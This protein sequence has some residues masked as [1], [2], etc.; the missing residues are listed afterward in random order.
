MH[1]DKSRTS[2]VFNDHIRR[3]SYSSA[4]RSS[5]SALESDEAA[6]VVPWGI[7]KHTTSLP[8]GG[9]DAA[10]EWLENYLTG[11]TDQYTLG[12]SPSSKVV[13]EFLFLS[14]ALLLRCTC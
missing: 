3:A 4:L 6:I 8:S 13:G 14:V 7:Y 9:A 10:K 5:F 11:L 12:C 2:L 1:E